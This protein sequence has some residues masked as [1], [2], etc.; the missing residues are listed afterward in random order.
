MSYFLRNESEV[1]IC[2]MDIT[3]AF[4]VK[5]LTNITVRLLIFMY[6][7]QKANV[8][9]A[10]MISKYF[11]MSNGVKQGAV[12]SAI[13]YC[14]YTDDLFKK[15]RDEK[16]GCWILIKFT[17][18]IGYDDDNLIMSPSLTCLQKMMNIWK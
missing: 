13:L 16:V 14:F 3:K 1:F 15:L 10:G 9:W 8:R 4:L 2:L 18:A 17:G 7:S 5:E 11:E 12:L 6:A